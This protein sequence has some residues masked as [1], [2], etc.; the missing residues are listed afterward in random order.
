MAK[1]TKHRIKKYLK[2][3]PLPLSAKLWNSIESIPRPTIE[4][5]LDPP[6]QGQ[7]IHK[8]AF[9][10]QMNKKKAYTLTEK[11]LRKHYTSQELDVLLATN[12]TPLDSDKVFGS[13]R[14]LKE[15]KHNQGFRHM[16]TQKEDAFLLSMQGHLTLNTIALAL[17]LPREA[18]YARL[19]SLKHSVADPEQEAPLIVLCERDNYEKDTQFFTRL[20]DIY[21]NADPKIA[22]EHP[23]QSI[24]EEV[25][26]RIARYRDPRARVG[27]H[28]QEFNGHYSTCLC[29]LC[30][31]LTNL[32][33]DMLNKLDAK[34]DDEGRT[35]EE[36]LKHN[37]DT[38]WAHGHP[39]DLPEEQRIGI[40]KRALQ[41]ASKLAE[42]R[43]RARKDNPDKAKALE[44]GNINDR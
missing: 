36:E 14:T 4:D 10:Y 28:N 33:E 20:D 40:I 37:P 1:I 31:G 39:I 9:V 27:T 23:V 6:K 3:S 2:G 18:V 19:M 5:V 21:Y 34:G 29:P 7:M 11:G 25:E 15:A 42:A 32:W 24:Y 30:T 22:G 41:G 35:I 43:K 44:M 12:N 38:L 13:Y 17:C 26:A 8:T 16:W